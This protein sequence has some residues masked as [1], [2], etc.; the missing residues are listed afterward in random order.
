MKKLPSWSMALVLLFVFVILVTQSTS[1]AYSVGTLNR[2]IYF[3]DSM[4]NYPGGIIF[5]SGAPCDGALTNPKCT[6]DTHSLE[7]NNTLSPCDAEIS[8]PCIEHI[9]AQ[10]SDGSWVEGIFS[11][12]RI[13]PWKLYAFA[14]NSKYE[15]SA[16]RRS[17]LYKFP[18]I[19]HDNGDLF[20]VVPN[21]FRAIKNGVPQMPSSLSTTIQGVYVDNSELPP[22]YPTSANSGSEVVTALHRCMEYTT[23]ATSSCWKPATQSNPIRMRISFRLPSL[24]SG[25]VT[26]RLLHPEIAYT[27]VST[28]SKESA[29]VT[30]TGAPLPTPFLEKSYFES[31]PDE[32]A[33]WEKLTA[34]FGDPWTDPYSEGPGV[35]P[36]SIKQYS[37]AVLL[38][39]SMNTATQVNDRWA[40]NLDWDLSLPGDSSC[41]KPGFLGYVGSN[42]LTYASL[43]PTFNKADGS[44]NYLVASPH[45]MPDGKVFNGD[46]ELVVADSY[47]RC[48]WGLS[49]APIQASISIVGDG[50]VAKVATTTVGVTNG[51]LSF[52]ATGF[53]FSTNHIKAIIRGIKLP[54]KKQTA[55]TCFKGKVVKKVSGA[56]PLCPSGFK[57][58]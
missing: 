44:L 53:T 48:I 17:N 40:A 25:W 58:K 51:T 33:V 41:A 11:G 9:W 15:I 50:G 28:N 57:R 35:G 18:G 5:S 43:L 14:A 26:G 4:N 54:A 29:R 34:V 45:F 49:N 36:T 21:F 55:I 2:D 22:A 46:Y 56:R 30:I 27:K 16:A 32:K 12:E 38:D 1:S 10:S 6:F 42:S 13:P 47:A 8:S 20:E 37:A 39:P 7:V 52:Q 3:A 23:E 31:Q 19:S 24:P